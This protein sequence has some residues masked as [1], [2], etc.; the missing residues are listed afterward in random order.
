MADPVRDELRFEPASPTRIAAMID[1]HW[2]GIVV[3]PERTY[4]AANLSGAFAR[5][6]GRE[7]ALV[8]WARDGATG[9]VVTLDAF[10]PGRGFGRRAL[11]FA[12]AE[13]AR[14]GATD[15]KLYTTNDNVRAIALYLRAGWRLVRVHLDAMDAVRAR[16]PGVPLTGEYGIPLRDMWEFAKPL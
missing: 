8:T 4:R 11:A 7:V 9:E 3:T 14:E 12:E 13:L 15:A 10:E 6:A 5:L 1:E 2:G 16:K